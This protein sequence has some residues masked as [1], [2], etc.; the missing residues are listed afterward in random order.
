MTKRIVG[1][2]VFLLFFSVASFCASAGDFYNYAKKMY[3]AGSYKK[4]LQ[5]ATVAEKMEPRNPVYARL[6]GDCYNKLGQPAVAQKFYKY[7]DRLGAGA[8]GSAGAQGGKKM[9]LTAFTGFTTVSMSAVNTEFA[10]EVAAIKLAYPA[11]TASAG[12]LGGGFIA[13]IN[14][15]YNILP[16]LP[17]GLKI[18]Y[19]SAFAA[20]FS[21]HV[22]TGL[23]TIDETGSYS[24]SI[25]PV[26]VGAAYNYALQG[27]PISLDGGLYFGLGFAGGAVNATAAGVS[28]NENIGGSAFVV[29][30]SADAKYHFSPTMS[31][32]LVLGYRMANVSQ[33]AA[34]EDN[35]TTGV[36][37][38]DV[39]KDSNGNAIPYDFS[40]LNINALFSIEF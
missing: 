22:D 24:A 25:I 23:G 15:G 31:A 2:L 19:I 29:E 38:G 3:D 8:G 20:D 32:G 27:M 16:Y 6:T 30:I 10:N 17:V 34:T 40:G 21:A 14:A 18:E 12:T 1:M 4:A 28:M 26:M 7:A 39:L 9:F 36:K 13:G 37:K 5:Y 35:S 33:M 11:A